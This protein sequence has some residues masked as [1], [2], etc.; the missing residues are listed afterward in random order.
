[1]IQREEEE[2][3]LRSYHKLSSEAKQVID[4]IFN[5]P[6]E[7][8]DLIYNPKRGGITKKR[9]QKMMENHWGD[10]K[11]PKKII[12]ELTKFVKTIKEPQC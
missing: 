2:E 6:S 10:K 9:I 8:M 7:I 12:K 4:I 5:A 3:T 11:E 1:M